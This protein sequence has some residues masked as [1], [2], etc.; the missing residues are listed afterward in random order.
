M[1]TCES[2][3][4]NCK[5]SLILLERRQQ[6]G[7]HGMMGWWVDPTN[8]TAPGATAINWLRCQGRFHVFLQLDDWVAV[9][10]LKKMFAEIISGVRLSPWP[11]WD[12]ELFPDSN[13]SYPPYLLT[14]SHSSYHR[15]LDHVFISYMFFFSQGFELLDSSRDFFWHVH[16]SIPSA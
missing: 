7:Q 1:Q 13:I 4:G 14:F 2:S 12:C 10:P 5:E 3:Q 15:I 9:D 16:R 11:L 8:P 6:W